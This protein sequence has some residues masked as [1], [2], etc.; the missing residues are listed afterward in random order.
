[1]K[2]LTK[3]V[4]GW[5]FAYAG[6]AALATLAAGQAG[7]QVAAPEEVITVPV[8]YLVGGISGYMIGETVAET[9]YDWSYEI[10]K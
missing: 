6:G 8:A 9:V 4:Y 3:K 1:M 2:T 7:P 5:S 10:F